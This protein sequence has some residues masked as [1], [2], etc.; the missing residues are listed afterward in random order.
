MKGALVFALLLAACGD[1]SSAAPP[2][3]QPTPTAHDKVFTDIYKDKTW[4]A[5]AD[6][7]GNSGTGSTLQATVV[8]RAFLQQ[9]MKENGI[10]S[11]VDAGCGDWE[12]SSAL[13]WKGIDYRGYDIVAALT[14]SNTEKYGK[15]NIKFFTGNIISDDL[16]A[17]DLIVSKDVLQHLPTKDVQAFLSKQLPK[18]KHALL[19]NGVD[20]NTLSGGNGDIAIGD[21]RPIDLARPPFN[22]KGTKVLTYWDGKH[23]HQV[24]HI[25]RP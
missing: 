11:V 24:V 22:V 15:A 16:P 2:P 9:F 18:Y 8:Y 4:G 14:K 20:M 12:F 10:K 13:D 23:M 3:P 6:G 21:Y 7:K 19:T 25:Q 17:A 1:S 5:N